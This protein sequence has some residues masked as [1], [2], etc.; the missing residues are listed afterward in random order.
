MW[1]CQKFRNGLGLKGKSGLLGSLRFGSGAPPRTLIVQLVA[2]PLS[3]LSS[4]T[5]Q[6][7]LRH[8]APGLLH[9]IRFIPHQ[10][11]HPTAH[12]HP[13]VLQP[14]SARDG[15]CQLRATLDNSTWIANFETN[16][17]RTSR[18]HRPRHDRDLV[19]ERCSRVS[20]AKITVVAW[21]LG[22]TS[23]RTSVWTSEHRQLSQG[24]HKTGY[25]PTV[26]TLRNIAVLEP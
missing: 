11:R 16:C 17:H 10:V 23:R 12:H 18:S 20:F 26:S 13:P 25:F 4:R 6:S 9:T 8:P 2:Q 14:P 21:R 22:R 5:R 19:S 15:F 24:G 3:T 7:H 1:K